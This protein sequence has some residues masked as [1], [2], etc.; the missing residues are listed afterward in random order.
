MLAEGST[1]PRLTLGKVLSLKV[2][3][4][5]FDDQRAVA[6]YLDVETARIDALIAKKRRMIDLLDEQL[7]GFIEAELLAMS[8]RRVTLRRLLREPPQYGAAESGETGESCSWPRYVRITDLNP[9]GSLR[10]DDIKRLSPSVARSYLLTDGDVLVARSGAT[11]G[12]TFIYRA[13]VGR[14]AFAGYLIRLSFDPAQYSSHLIGHWSQTGDYWRQIRAA[15]LQATIENVSAERYKELQVPYPERGVQ[16]T[17]VARFDIARCCAA[18]GKGILVRQVNLLTEHRQ[19]VITAAVTGELA[20][21]R[22][23]A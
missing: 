18:R 1:R 8:S 7:S 6:D 11:V 20:I 19:A 13:A 23:A 21:P 14:A 15:S 10:E 4:F 9:D 17:L 22:V 3:S 12:K 5:P 16:D 2:P